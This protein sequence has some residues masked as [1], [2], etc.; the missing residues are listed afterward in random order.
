M[1]EDVGEQ[2]RPGTSRQARIR[3]RARANSV[4]SRLRLVRLFARGFDDAARYVATAGAEERTARR[5]PDAGKFSAG[6][7]WLELFGRKP[8]V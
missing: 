4:A 8:Q 7:A 3:P 6:R 1:R 2:T 5:K